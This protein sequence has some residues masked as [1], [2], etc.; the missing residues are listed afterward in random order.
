MTPWLVLPVKSIADGK[1]RLAP[2]LDAHGRRRLNTR[3]LRGALNLATRFPGPDRTVVVSRCAGVLAVADAWGAHALA[4]QGGPDMNDAI[5]QAVAW[6][7]RVADTPVLVM[8]CDMPLARHEDLQH[9][10]KHCQGIRPAIALATDRRGS[11]TNALALPS[12]ACGFRFHYGPD[13]RLLH[14]LEAARVG[15]ACHVLQGTS[16]AFDVD[17]YD[18]LQTWAGA[19]EVGVPA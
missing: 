16:L 2:H 9:L 4:E 14:G 1:S 7:R 3:L 11:G 19:R 12:A 8:S 15:L 6:V 10:V 17:T 5:T 13:S 18:D